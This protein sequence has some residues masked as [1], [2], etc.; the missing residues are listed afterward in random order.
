MMKCNDMIVKEL[1][2]LVSDVLGRHYHIAKNTPTSLL[3]KK[4]S[5]AV[6][7]VEPLKVL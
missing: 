6:P 3:E 5:F 4:G 1:S 7:Q 2:E